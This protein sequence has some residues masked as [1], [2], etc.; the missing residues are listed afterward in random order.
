MEDIEMLLLKLEEEIQCGKKALFGNAVSINPENCLK[1]IAK[2]KENLPDVIREA[3]RII[4]EKEQIKADASERASKMIAAANAKVEEL[5]AETNIVKKA[6]EAADT[7]VA[8]AREFEE[9]IVSGV[10]H[11]LGTLLENSERTLSDAVMLV[12][13]SREELLGNIIPSRKEDND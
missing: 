4:N 9:N 7:I 11:N 8:E 12:R 13:E 6:Q 3:H 5:L 10:K 2:V 1:L